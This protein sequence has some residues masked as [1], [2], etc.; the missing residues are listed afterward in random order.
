MDIIINGAILFIL[1]A[2][3]GSFLNVVIYR[4]N[5]G[6]SPLSGRS[7][8]FTCGKTLEWYELIPL[9]SFIIQKGRCRSCKTRL[10]WQYPLVEVL[11]GVSF[12]VVFSLGKPM[13]ETFYLFAIF[14]ILLVIAVYDLRHQI[15][16]DGFAAGFAILSLV[17]FLGSLPGGFSSA[18][19]WPHY[20][21]LLA[22]PLL[23]LPFWVLW[24]VSEGRW[25]GLGDGKLALG[26]GWFL[27]ITLGASALILA[28]WIG[29][30]YALAM[31]ALQYLRTSDVRLMDVGR[32]SMR[33][34]SLKSEIPF[35]PFLIL[36]VFIVYFTHINFFDGSIV[37]FDLFS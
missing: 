3:I 37:L 14:S 30:V 18:A 15:I 28:F 8:C 29:A 16:P 13:L 23:F 7:Q 17:W 9:L 36:G 33:R 22:G 5:S 6:T 24:Y 34:L 25:M 27:G 35:G 21:T 12:L 32:P 11:T 4:Y 19:T 20:W 26:I 2:I 31:L 10:S 1:G